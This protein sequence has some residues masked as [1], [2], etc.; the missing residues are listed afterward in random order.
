[1]EKVTTL[2]T[3]LIY[4]KETKDM[5]L[6]DIAKS[7]A[8]QKANKG[9]SMYNQS[10]ILNNATGDLER[11]KMEKLGTYVWLVPKQL[12]L[13]FNPLELEDPTFNTNNP[14]IVPT[15][16]EK[17]IIALKQVMRENKELHSYIAKLGGLKEESYD[18][19]ED[20]VTDVD[21]KIFNP[22]NSVLQQSLQTQKYEFAD[23]GQYGT[24][25]LTLLEI[26]DEG[27]FSAKSE[28]MLSY[29]L[30][31]LERDIVNEKV[32]EY[33][34]KKSK[35]S[36]SKDEKEQITAIKRSSQV[37]W[38]KL[39]GVLM[40]LEYVADTEKEELL[41]IDEPTNLESKLR[42]I[43]CSGEL[44]KKILKRKG[45]RADKSINY[46]EL[47]VTYGDG[48][49]TSDL[50]EE[51]AL[52]QS[53]EFEKPD[54][55]MM[56]SEIVADFDSLYNEYFSEGM[57]GKF[58]TLAKRNIWKFSH[59]TD[60]ALMTAASGRMKEIVPYVTMDVFNQHISLI[61]KCNLDIAE[62]LRELNDEGKLPVSF[63]KMVNGESRETMQA[64]ET[65]DENIIDEEV[66]DNGGSALE[67]LASNVIE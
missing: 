48:K 58:E 50:T 13:P 56:V 35:S 59:I 29:Q 46:L 5:N 65:M 21:F 24:E 62:Q 15:T 42:Y 8:E 9:K 40:F 20:V 32:A 17:A 39:S 3:N 43:N 54:D 66:V 10:E 12:Q 45:K 33:L 25:R 47:K 53:R 4:L 27:Q 1:M 49:P 11:H 23:F 57:A 2:Y 7:I 16:P 60:S 26:D 30:L 36:L 18:V 44:L 19:S 31:M 64:I 6:A 67:D 28:G 51:L 41:P 52:Y 34:L 38:P 61:E 63:T 55:E 14:Y 22:F 37:K